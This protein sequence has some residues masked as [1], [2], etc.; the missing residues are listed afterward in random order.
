[1]NNTAENDLFGFPKVKWLQ[2]TTK[3]GKCTSYRCQIFSGF[4]TPKIIKIGY[5][6]DR[7]IGKIQRGPFFCGHSLYV[8]LTSALQVL[9]TMHYINRHFTYLL[10]YYF[11]AVHLVTNNTISLSTT[12]LLT[13]MDNYFNGHYPSSCGLA[14]SL[15]K[16]SEKTCGSL[17]IYW[18]T[19][20]PMQITASNVLL[21]DCV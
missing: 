6:F 18:P 20:H 2:Y 11:I 17:D 13:Y 16:A 7:A 14:S 4:N 9:M 12:Y 21:I 8:Y 1:M 5:F 19:R 3:V 15:R 10:T